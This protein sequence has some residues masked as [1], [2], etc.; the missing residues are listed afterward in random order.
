MNN[1][2]T[3]SRSTVQM[4]SIRAAVA[5]RTIGLNSRV[6]EPHVPRIDH[7]DA[8]LLLARP[9]GVEPRTENVAKPLLDPDEGPLVVLQVDDG[10][11]R[12]ERL[13]T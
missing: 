13:P 2:P 1:T 6:L 10:R 7:L 11:A 4:S 12:T 8:D 5:E 3:R 9:V